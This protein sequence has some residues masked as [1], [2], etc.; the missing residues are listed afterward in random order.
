[1]SE[2]PATPL[3]T[4]FSAPVEVTHLAR[5]LGVLIPV[6]FEADLWAFCAAGAAGAG[7]ALEPERVARYLLT[8]LVRALRR[9]G[10]APA[11]LPYRMALGRLELSL[12]A[13]VEQSGI[14]VADVG[15]I[16]VPPRAAG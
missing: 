4:S 7:V 10:G 9:T 16:A 12:V 13:R 15:A 2:Q 14:R 3:S 11:L 5:P 1:M 8:G 6:H